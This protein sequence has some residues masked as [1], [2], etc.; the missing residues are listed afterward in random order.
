MRTAI[1]LFNENGV[2]TTGI[3]KIIA[4]SGV[5][6][7]TFYKHF[8]SKKALVNAYL[9][10]RDTLQFDRLDRFTTQKTNDPALRILGAFDALEEWFMEDDFKGCAFTRGLSDFGSDRAS[11][12]YQLV[13][14]H[15][16]RWTVFF[17]EELRKLLPAEKIKK[18][19][20]QLLTLVVGTTVMA[21]A[22]AGAGVAKINKELAAK[23]LEIEKG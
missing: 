10:F 11:D 23:L 1:I 18:V 9:E 7:M 5:A 15:F 20:P 13:L 2:H 21:T 16:Q 22:G 12:S 8:P 14:Q 3:D 6:K 4:E 19:L 17:E